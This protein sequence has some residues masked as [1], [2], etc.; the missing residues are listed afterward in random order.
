MQGE[1]LAPRCQLTLTLLRCTPPAG[2]YRGGAGITEGD[3]LG[4]NT[5]SGERSGRL[6]RRRLWPLGR[7][8]YRADPDIGCPRSARWDTRLRSLGARLRLVRTQLRS[9]RTWLRQVRTL[10]RLAGKTHN[11]ENTA[12]NGKVTAQDGGNNAAQTGE[13]RLKMVRTQFKM[14]QNGGTRLR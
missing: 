2:L 13:T 7:V 11:G 9:V 4:L 5:S 12:Q 8:P 14:A 1:R 3:M 6:D 10:L